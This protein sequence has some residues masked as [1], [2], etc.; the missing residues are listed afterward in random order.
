MKKGKTPDL[1]VADV[2]ADDIL[3]EYDFSGARPNRYAAL[4]QKGGLTVDGSEDVGSPRDGL[5]Y[6][7]PPS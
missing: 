3:P 4:Y 6:E 2:D 7:A 5:P 1:A